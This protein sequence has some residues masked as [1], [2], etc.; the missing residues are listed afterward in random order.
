M[1]YACGEMNLPKIAGSV[2]SGCWLIFAIFWAVS[3]LKSKATAERQSWLSSLAHRLLIAAGAWLLWY[4]RFSGPLRLPLT[5]H[6]DGA[7]TCAAMVCVAGLWV[8]LWARWTLGGNWSS[9]VTFK[10]GHELVQ[11]GPYR[12]VRHPIYTGLMLMCLGT[13]MAGGQLHAWLSLLAFGAG[14]W[15]KL[16][17]EEKLLLRHFPDQYPAY[18]KQV[19]ALVPFV[20]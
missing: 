3:A 8:T 16:R 17:Q 1:R 5:P 2:I 19:K 15:I 20:W 13:V 7:G 4:P 11:S 6:G 12:M 10:Q 9:I 14:F 18:R